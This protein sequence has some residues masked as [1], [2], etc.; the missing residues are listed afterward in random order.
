MIHRF[1]CNIKG[2]YIYWDIRNFQDRLDL[3]NKGATASRWIT[4]AWPRW[5]EA[6]AVEAK[7]PEEHWMKSRHA[8]SQEA[9]HS[10]TTCLGEWAC[11]TTGLVWLLLRWCRTFSKTSQLCAAAI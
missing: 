4:H 8:A 7:I 9:T 11:S 3:H 10:P 5:L 2:A 1:D 6:S